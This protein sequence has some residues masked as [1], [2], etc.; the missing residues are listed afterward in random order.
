MRF[1]QIDRRA[2]YNS[3][4]MNWL[5]NPSTRAEAWQV[6]DYRSIPTDTLFSRLKDEQIVLDKYS[7]LSL[8]E[9]SDTPEDLTDDLLADSGLDAS[10]QDKIYLLIFELWRRLAP[11]K[12]S[13]SLFC[14]ELD[15]QIFLYDTEQAHPEELQDAI[16]NLEI[17][18]DKNFDSGIDPSTAFETLSSGCANDLESFLYDFISEQ[19]EL[20]NF[21]Y[22]S[23]LIEG[24]SRY[25]QDKRWFE[26]LQAQVIANSDPEAANAIIRGLIKKAAKNPDFEFT[27]ELLSFVSQ[28][29]DP[30]VFHSLVKASIPLLT[31]EEDFKELLTLSADYFTRLD[32]DKEEQR[33]QTIIHSRNAFLPHVKFNPKDPQV[34][35]LL[36]ISEAK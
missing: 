30:D 20:G 31:S 16:A 4:R 29:G 2:L 35:E 8:S 33:I 32:R 19:V 24:F 25:I 3:L 26:F 17:L 21:S 27:M 36:K 11:E 9:S 14:D 23:E 7:F 5:W 12:Q 1:M 10:L 13:I 22:A 34:L 6:E 15:H 28:S 18:L